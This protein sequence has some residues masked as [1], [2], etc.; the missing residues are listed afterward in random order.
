MEPNPYESP[1]I[2]SPGKL[3]S[4]GPDG[5]IRLLTEIRD[6]QQEMLS[7]Y[8]RNSA[9]QR[10]VLIGAI[11]VLALTAVIGLGMLAVQMFRSGIPL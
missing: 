9:I 2:P 8:R 4:H 7:I 5:T 10:F 1:V 3:Q 6:N 11:L